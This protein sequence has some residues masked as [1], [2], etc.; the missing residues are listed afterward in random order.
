VLR[1]GSLSLGCHKVD[2]GE[3]EVEE[4]EPSAAA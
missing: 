4:S 1:L 3:D 2:W